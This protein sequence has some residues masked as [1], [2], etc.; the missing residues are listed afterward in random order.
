MEGSVGPGVGVTEGTGVEVSVGAGVGVAEGI[1]V[2]V[3]VGVDDSSL[4]AAKDMTDRTTTMPTNTTWRI[5]IR[6]RVPTGNLTTSST[7]PA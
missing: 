5:L 2:E 4:H 7:L 1:G 6:D 3:S